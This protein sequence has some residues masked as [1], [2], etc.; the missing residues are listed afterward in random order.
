MGE[1]HECPLLPDKRPL[2][3]LEQGI[4][5]VLLL[6]SGV[7]HEPEEVAE[8]AGDPE[9]SRDG[10]RGMSTGCDERGEVAAIGLG[11]ERPRRQGVLRTGWSIR[12]PAAL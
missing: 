5:V 7:Q 11:P 6:H 1:C 12:W 3:Q 4:H 9:G 8:A 2:D 10:G